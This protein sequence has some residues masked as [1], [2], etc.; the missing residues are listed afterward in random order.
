LTQILPPSSAGLLQ[1]Q[2]VFEV[3][4]QALRCDFY[5]SHAFGKESPKLLKPSEFE[6]EVFGSRVPSMSGHDSK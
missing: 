4:P 2:Y 3:M 5:C 6:V 1:D